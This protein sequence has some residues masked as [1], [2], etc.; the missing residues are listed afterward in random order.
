MADDQNQGLE[1]LD[2]D[3]L[4]NEDAND[5]AA[6]AF[7]ALRNTVETL[8]ADLTREMMTIRSGI[9]FALDRMEQRGAPV[10]YSPE[11]GRM[12]RNQAETN[13]RLQAIEQSSAL[14][15]GPEHYARVI[16][17]SGESLVRTAAQH[18]ERQASDL[19]RAGRN[20]SAHVASARERNR[21]NR[22]FIIAAFCGMLAGVVLTLFL[23]AMLPF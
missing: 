21:Q 15:H 20:L 1:D 10:D 14:K 9:E 13:E 18:L 3:I 4:N 6:V 2:T 11:I 5:P 23:P 22:W 7:E 19:E 12:E 8:A 17:N 16:E